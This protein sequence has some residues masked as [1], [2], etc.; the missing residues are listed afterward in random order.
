MF[1]VVAALLI[2][3]FIHIMMVQGFVMYLEL[4]P[5]TINH[6]MPSIDVVL[7]QRGLNFIAQAPSDDLPSVSNVNNSTDSS[8]LVKEYA[9]NQASQ[10]FYSTNEIDRKALPQTSIDQ[11]VLNAVPY[12]GLPIHLR[13]FINA[14]GR[15]IKIERIG[16]L[17]Q[18]NLFISELEKQLYQMPFLPARRNGEDVNSYQDAQF[19]FNQTTAFIEH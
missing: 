10:V 8:A 18:D 5:K 16:V 3:I 13:L 19:S 1:R 15:L 2:S 17:E 14:S 11:V 9:D 6:Q 4:I 7:Q 12:S